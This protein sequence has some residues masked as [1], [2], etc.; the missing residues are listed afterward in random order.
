MPNTGICCRVRRPI[1]LLLALALL[2]GASPQQEEPAPIH[3]RVVSRLSVARRYLDH[4]VPFWTKRVPQLTNG[5]VQ[6]EI[7]PFD[8]SGIPEQA[9]L[10]LLRLGVIAFGTV[11]LGLAS[12]NEPELNAIDLPALNPDLATLR[13][14]VA[15][16]RPYFETLL[17][18]RYGV[19]LLAV[20]TDAAQVVFCRDPFTSLDDLAGRRV[21]TSSV[22]QSDLVTALRGMP[23]VIPF[24]EMAGAV[25]QG[26]VDCAITGALSGNR[27]GLHAVTTHVSRQGISWAVSI[28]AANRAAWL[29]LP[30][31]VQAR[32]REGLAKLQEEIWAAAAQTTEDGLA[33][34]AGLPACRDGR[35]GRMTVVEEYWVSEARRLQ[36]LGEA[37]LPKWV[38]R[39]GPACA[40][41]W[42]RIAAPSAHIWATEE[43]E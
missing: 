25:R 35:R 22:S 40:T 37:M 4:E 39:C 24:A 7:V 9:M 38:A 21:R 1:L 41:A 8:G 13:G 23:V 42:N 10:H 3:L 36:L 5:R 26:V 2:G 14:T 18:E 32:L 15:Q 28:F 12:A 31:G 11:P 17:R 29:A 19:E 16:W 43:M 27:V 20:Y 6:A 34:N 30:E 33:C